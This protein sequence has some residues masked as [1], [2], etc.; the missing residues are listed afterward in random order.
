MNWKRIGLELAR[1]AGAGLVL[2]VAYQFMPSR[3]RANVPCSIP[4]TFV[5]GTVADATQV[6][7]NFNALVTCLGNAAVAG[8]NGDIT[9]LTGLST[10]LTPASGGTSQFMA[11]GVTTGSGNVQGI[12]ATL[13]NNFS[14]TSG[15][16]VS[17]IAGFSNNNATTLSIGS[18]AARNLFRKTTQFGAVAMV[19]GE[20]VAGNAYSAIYDGTEYVL[21]GNTDQVAE[22]RLWHGA[23][24]SGWIMADGNCY[25]TSNNLLAQ[26]F[27]VIGTNYG[28][29]GGST[30]NVP[31]VRGRNLTGLDNMGTGTGAAGLLT[32]AGTGCGS[33]FN[34]VNA[35][36]A[37]GSQSH[38]QSLAE[39]ANH[40]HSATSS[41]SDPGHV[42]GGGQ[43]QSQNGT[44]GGTPSVF[45]FG[46]PVNTSGAT[47]GITVGTTVNANGSSQAMPIVN[48]NRG[49]YVIMKE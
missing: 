31:D 19:G 39:L 40:N 35:T 44:A 9:Q 36:C 15:Y 29:C 42:H 23:A 11:T 6:N 5:N 49:F 12:A 16:R 30:F 10:P 2:V 17:F 47:T 7:A 48:P 8:V 21:D 38:T 20:L 22:M 24:P 4:F 43:A 3:T 46:S 26:I 18:T 14:L 1:V 37:N 13:P 34:V 25:A 41:V 28:S 33:N 45:W 32:G 27:A